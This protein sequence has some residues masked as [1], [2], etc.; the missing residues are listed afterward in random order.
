MQNLNK[1]IPQKDNYQEVMIS[2]LTKD[3]WAFKFSEDEHDV[4]WNNHPAINSL[5]PEEKSKICL[6]FFSKM[7]YNN[8]D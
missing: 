3:T 4:V 7:Y 5:R 8:A 2:N 1:E 6:N